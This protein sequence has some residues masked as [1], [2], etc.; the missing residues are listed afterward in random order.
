MSN[1][2]EKLRLKA[3]AEEDIYFAKRDRELIKALHERKLAKHLKLE[4]K[5]KK[6]KAQVLE[7]KYAAATVENGNKLKKLGKCYRSLIDKALKL[8]KRKRR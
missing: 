3:L 1:F 6:K 8:I 5:K 4:A 2:P 7:D